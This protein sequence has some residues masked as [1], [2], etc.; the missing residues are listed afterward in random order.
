MEY[1]KPHRLYQFLFSTLC[2]A[3]VLQVFHVFF[4][5]SPYGTNF[6]ISWNIFASLLVVSFFPIIS[7]I[8]KDKGKFWKSIF[9]YLIP[10]LVI[11]VP[12]VLIVVWLGHILPYYF[13]SVIVSYASAMLAINIGR[14]VPNRVF[15]VLCVL[16]V[17][18]I[19][20]TSL[21]YNEQSKI[22]PNIRLY[23]SQFPNIDVVSS[24]ALEFAQSYPT[25]QEAYDNVEKH[26]DSKL[27]NT[28]CDGYKSLSRKKECAQLLQ[29]TKRWV[30]ESMKFAILP[31]TR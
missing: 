3:L 2:S 11:L 16:W 25:A 6:P 8:N 1:I 24:E 7:V 19:Y 13:L 22:E 31:K 10:I 23:K 30:V 15:Y 26:V 29:S 9:I 17:P 4:D 18:L 27:P 14:V 28:M 20:F 5:I 21:V 12:I